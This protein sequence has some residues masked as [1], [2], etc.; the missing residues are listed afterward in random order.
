MSKSET[1][2]LANLRLMDAFTCGAK[3]E[4][5]KIAERLKKISDSWE[6]PTEAAVEIG[7]VANELLKEIEES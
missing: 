2:A 7:L 3:F 1:V 4:A 6:C 5:K